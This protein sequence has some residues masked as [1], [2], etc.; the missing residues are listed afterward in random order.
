VYQQQQ[1]F[2]AAFQVL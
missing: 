1:T 2:F